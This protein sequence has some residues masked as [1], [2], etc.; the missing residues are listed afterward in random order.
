MI[1]DEELKL[2]KAAYQQIKKQRKKLIERFANSEE[3]IADTQPMS[4]FMAGSP[5]AGKTEISTRLSVHFTQKPIRIDADEIRTFCEGYTGENSHIFQKAASKGVH[6]LY[7]YA[8]K[9][10]I[11]VILDGTFAY[12]GALKNIKR[13]LDHGR[14]V[15]IYFVYQDPLK[16]WEFTKKREVIE[17]RKISKEIFIDSF[18]K[19]QENTN[20]AKK[21][22]G[23]SIELNLIVNNFEKN[24]ERLELNISSIDSFI[25]KIYT[26]NELNKLIL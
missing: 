13:S 4:F 2:S 22:F 23:S 12:H 10:N 24:L 14:K 1:S 20:E 17:H 11:N 7:D 18:I 25:K 3:Y 16:A 21:H 9:K 26:K 15:E 19:A 5:G 6:I 8:L